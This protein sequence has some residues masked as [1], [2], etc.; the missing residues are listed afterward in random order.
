MKIRTCWQKRMDD[1]LKTNI[2]TGGGIPA[3]KLGTIN[4]ACPFM[5]RVDYRG[6]HDVTTFHTESY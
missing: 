1:F 4:E 6:M 5:N 3:V 2:Q